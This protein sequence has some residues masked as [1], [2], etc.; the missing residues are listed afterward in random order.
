MNDQKRNRTTTFRMRHDKRTLAHALRFAACFL[1]F[2]AMTGCEPEKSHSAPSSEPAAK[3]TQTAPATQ[4]AH[5]AATESKAPAESTRAA[6]A[7][8]NGSKQAASATPSTP[9]PSGHAA[10]TPPATGP[11]TPE[12]LKLDSNYYP[13]DLV[14][15]VS[16]D[17]MDLTT[18]EAYARLIPA[19]VKFIASSGET[20]YRAG[21]A[22][23]RPAIHLDTAGGE[24]HSYM[25]VVGEPAIRYYSPDKTWNPWLIGDD[26]LYEDLFQ[27][28]QAL[29]PNRLPR[30]DH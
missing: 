16:L 15:K 30:G 7:T 23:M 4:P 18:Q 5:T 17:G 12:T 3:P 9:A 29:Y 21:T 6:G 26:K 8:T 2:L 24:R 13:Q 22:V 14:T 10:A 28:L 11:A 25:L 19:L 27:A 20:S 1:V